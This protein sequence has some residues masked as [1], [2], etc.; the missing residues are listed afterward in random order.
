MLENNQIQSGS[1]LG[2][3]AVVTG[4]SSGIGLATAQKLFAEG[5]KVILIGRNHEKLLA[6]NHKLNDSAVILVAD[7]SVR[8]QLEKIALQIKESFG[9]IDFLINCAGVSRVQER[10]IL[11]EDAFDELIDVN[12][13]GT[14]LCSMIFGYGLINPGGAIVNISSIRGRTGTTSFSA[15]YAVAKAGVINLTKTFALE[16]AGSGIRVNGVAPGP[17]YPTAI[18]E[19][20]STEMIKEISQTVPLK[21]LG[22]PDEVANA[23]YFL[24]SDLSSYMTGQTLDLNGGLWMN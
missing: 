16:L 10:G 15:G 12:L 19:K 20:W 1:L 14:Y 6:A 9:K 17:I 22:R 11:N 4:S 3:V 7:I 13:K 8:T 2:K 5:A 24:V 21:R 18:S 23:V